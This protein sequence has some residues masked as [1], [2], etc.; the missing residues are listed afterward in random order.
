MT[1][2]QR[3]YLDG[4]TDISVINGM[5]HVTGSNIFRRN[6]QDGTE[7]TLQLAFTVP[8]FALAC[9]NMQRM[10]AVL[11]EKG[12]LPTRADKESVETQTEGSAKK[13]P[14]GKD[15]ILADVAVF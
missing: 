11:E 3:I 13:S 1:A 15:K 12:L 10:I 14:G 4:F 6:G 8:G 7:T 5:V 2:P 9:E